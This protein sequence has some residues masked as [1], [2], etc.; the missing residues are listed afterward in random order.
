[1]ILYES[2][3]V[4]SCCSNKQSQGPSGWSISQSHYTASAHRQRDMST[5]L[6]H[7]LRLM[8]P[9]LSACSISVWS[10]WQEEE[11]TES[12]TLALNISTETWH[13]DSYFIGQKQVTWP[14]LTSKWVQKR[15]PGLSLGEGEKE[16]CDQPPVSPLVKDEEQRSELLWVEIR[17]VPFDSKLQD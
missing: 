1:M 5:K 3:S 13:I 2:G 8:Q 7:V 6:I 10:P 4:R 17:E 9:H 15:D 14:L 11:D 16:D 12:H